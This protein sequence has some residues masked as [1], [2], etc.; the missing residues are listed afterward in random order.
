MRSIKAAV[1]GAQQIRPLDAAS[2]N[3]E[4]TAADT[5]DADADADEPRKR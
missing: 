2:V 4:Q 5:Q 1:R 3:L